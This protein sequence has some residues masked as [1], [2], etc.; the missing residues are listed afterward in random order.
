MKQYAAILLLGYCFAI[1][2]SNAQPSAGQRA[3]DSTQAL[4]WKFYNADQPDS[5]YELTNAN[6]QS[7]FTAGQFRDFIMG[8]KAGL[9]QWQSAQSPTFVGNTWHYQ[10]SFHS[11]T[12]DFLLQ[13]DAQRKISLFALK[14]YQS[15]VSRKTKVLTNNP[16]RTSLD[17]QVDEAMRD[18]VGDGRT[19]GLTIG[20]LRHDSLF[21]FGYG[22]TATGTGRIPN[23][24]T[25]FEIGSVTKT[26][27]AALLADAVRRGVVH[28]DD[29]V[30]QYLPDSIPPLR[31]KGVNVTLK[32]LAQSYVR[33]P[34][35]GYQLGYWGYLLAS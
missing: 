15:P 27:T 12:M 33:S 16:L 9:G 19:V 28:L 30:S 4:V 32:M 7:Q 20:I 18:Y 29:P 35:H 3:V 23:D 5:I 6:F 2:T 14:P 1:L 13:L 25:L 8:A 10:T 17:R 21:T 31:Y 22:E 11:A 24:S 26:F 34:P